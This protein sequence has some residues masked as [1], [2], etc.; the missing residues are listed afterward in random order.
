MENVRTGSMLDRL[1]DWAERQNASD[2]HG[3]ADKPFTVRVNGQM[4]KVPVDLF[5]I[6]DGDGMKELLQQGLSAKAYERI[7]REREYDMSFYW[8]HL[9][10]RGNFSKQMGQ[11][12]F[13]LRSVPQHVFRL[14]DLQLPESLASLAHEHRGLVIVCG[15]T[16][17]GKS[18]TLRALLQEANAIRCVRIITIEDPV[19]YIFTDDKS[20]FEQRE[21]GTETNS[22]ADGIRNAM[23]QDP[24]MILIGEIRDR[25]SVAAA[26]QASETGH[27]VLTSFH[28]D[29][30]THAVSRLREFFAITEQ[31]QLGSLL[32]RNIHAIIS[33]RLIPNLQGKRTPCLE[34]L[35]RDR[36]VQ[37][38]IKSND[39]AMLNGIL[40]AAGQQG[41]QTF[42]Q[43]LA[44]L[45]KDGTIK[46]EIALQ[47]AANRHRLDLALKG[48]VTSTAILSRDVR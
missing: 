18:T 9:R 13:A 38:A 2:V 35:R 1:L 8:G 27:L 43:C 47:Y 28:A 26:L 44:K 45:L 20:Q 33:Q 30:V 12:T 22:F 31:E 34:I 15:P 3:Q 6:R 7:E 21:V 25:E 5:P 41:M 48:F 4:V 40:E 37:D 36:G 39:M 32:S 42:D 23:R 17:Q 10:F 46:K 19:E 24:D 29:S 11:Q 16:G 14:K